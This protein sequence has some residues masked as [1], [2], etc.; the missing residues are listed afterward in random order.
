MRAGEK[1]PN[2]P[3]AA[4]MRMGTSTCPNA[5]ERGRE[6]DCGRRMKG[7]VCVLGGSP[8]ELEE[9]GNESDALRIDRVRATGMPSTCTGAGYPAPTHVE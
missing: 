5:D 4:A 7:A 1:T 2:S 8:R 3:R 9:E 6:G